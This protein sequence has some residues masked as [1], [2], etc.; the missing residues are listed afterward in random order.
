MAKHYRPGDPGTDAWTFTTERWLVDPP[1]N[2]RLVIDGSKAIVYGAYVVTKR[3]G[4]FGE[5][6]RALEADGYDVAV[7]SPTTTCMV[8]ALKK[9]GFTNGLGWDNTE[10]PPPVERWRRERR[11]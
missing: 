7:D 9:H 8:N 6:C 10:V 5:L 1:T 2:S 4:H 11:P 3:Q